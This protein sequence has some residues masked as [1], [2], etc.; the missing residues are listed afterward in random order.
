MWGWNGNWF[1]NIIL[2]IRILFFL[3]AWII[4]YPFHRGKWV[5]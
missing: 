1:E 5:I 2:S 3:I 4:T